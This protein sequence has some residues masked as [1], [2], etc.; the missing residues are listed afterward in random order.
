MAERPERI[1][2]E[3]SAIHLKTVKESDTYILEGVL[4]FTINVDCGMPFLTLKGE[5]TDRF[6]RKCRLQGRRDGTTQE[7][8]DDMDTR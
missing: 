6:V 7:D 1:A 5:N 3:F 8:R 2:P 4:R